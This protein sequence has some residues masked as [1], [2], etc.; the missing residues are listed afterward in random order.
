[1]R[2]PVELLDFRKADVDLR[3]AGLFQPLEHRRQS[4]A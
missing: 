1:L 3:A 2:Q 4:E